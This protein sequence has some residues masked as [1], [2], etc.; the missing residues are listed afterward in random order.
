MRGAIEMFSH[1]R[2]LLILVLCD[3]PPPPNNPTG[4]V[5]MI[6]ICFNAAEFAGTTAKLISD[7]QD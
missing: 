6:P 4:K 3:I 2:A 7:F 1:F 5:E